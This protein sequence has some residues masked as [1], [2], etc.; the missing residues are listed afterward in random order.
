MPESVFAAVHPWHELLVPEPLVFNGWLLAPS[1]RTR[2]FHPHRL[3]LSPAVPP[4]QR[5]ERDDAEEDE[6]G[7][8]D[9]EHSTCTI[10]LCSIKASDASTGIAVLHCGHRFHPCCISG[11]LSHGSERQCPVCRAVEGSPLELPSGSSTRGSRRRRQ[12]SIFVMGRNLSLWFLVH[13]E[14]F[15]MIVSYGYERALFFTGSPL[16]SSALGAAWIALLHSSLPGPRVDQHPLQ[17]LLGI[18]STPRVLRCLTA[19]F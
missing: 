16:L 8:D 14:F 10:C 12:R 3:P 15:N 6:L 7:G 19:W 2:S 17:V 18:Q 11:W 1:D 13:H 5:A 4:V 9:D